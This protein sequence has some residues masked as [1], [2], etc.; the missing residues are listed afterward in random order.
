MAVK[1]FWSFNPGETLVAEELLVQ[2]RDKIE[3]YFPIKDTGIDI[4][5]ITRKAKKVVTFQVKESRYYDKGKG[6]AWHQEHKKTFLR[7]K[8][9]VD[10]YVFVI[11]Y[12]GY[13]AG[14]KKKDKFV[15]HYIV[16]PGDEI[17]ERIKY[18]KFNKAGKY[19][20]YFKIDGDKVFD[21]REPASEREKKSSAFDYSEFLNAWG[22]VREIATD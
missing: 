1:N 6:F 15:I 16:V 19:S 13:L 11:Y 7:N 5:A 3:L 20:F 8:H 22:K 2:L 4:V 18:K 9:R 12:P 10:F 17:Q 14:T 21:V